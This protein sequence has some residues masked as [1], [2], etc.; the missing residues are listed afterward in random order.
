MRPFLRGGTP[1]EAAEV[2]T[3]PPELPK[4]RSQGAAHRLQTERSL[5]RLRRTTISVRSRTRFEL[6]SSRFVWSLW[7]KP[8]DHARRWLVAADNAPA[9][10]HFYS[11]SLHA[12]RLVKSN[13]AN[14]LSMSE[15]GY[16]RVGY[17]DKIRELPFYFPCRT[18]RHSWLVDPL[19][20]YRS[21]ASYSKSVQR[22][23][24]QAMS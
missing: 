20:P 16:V 15:S 4:C 10:K 18:V 23:P 13:L 19:L 7:T 24:L 2:A 12:S 8:V 9:R 1:G 11:V 3:P 21:S 5:A 14:L 17:I 22:A 6:A